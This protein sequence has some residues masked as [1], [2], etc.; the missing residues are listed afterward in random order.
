M[1]FYILV[2]QSP[3]V[4]CLYSE[5]NSSRSASEAG[6]LNSFTSSAAL[7]NLLKEKKSTRIKK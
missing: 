4:A 6:A 1:A 3:T 7:L 5:Y 2:L